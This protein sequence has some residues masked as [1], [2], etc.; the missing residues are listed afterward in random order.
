VTSLEKVFPPPLSHAGARSRTADQVFKLNHY[1]IDRLTVEI[2]AFEVLHQLGVDLFSSFA[3]ACE[4][5][6]CTATLSKF[7][8]LGGFLLIA[9]HMA[10]Q[11]VN[12]LNVFC[13]SY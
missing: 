12:L 6:N 7:E 4:V 2:D 1:A 9:L 10:D 3:A 13:S 11:L 5:V 8:G